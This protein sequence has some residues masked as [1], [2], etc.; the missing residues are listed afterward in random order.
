MKSRCKTFLL[1]I[2]LMMV[3]AIGIQA[4][5]K[6]EYAVI[7][8]RPVTRNVEV[9]IN[10][11]EYKTIIPPKEKMKGAADVNPALEEVNKMADDNWELFDTGY[12]IGDATMHSYA[13]FLRRK[14]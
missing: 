13:F 1:A 3:T 8:Y 11:I 2:F 5:E 12:S 4:Q 9:S 7:T 14:K 6:Y 10:G